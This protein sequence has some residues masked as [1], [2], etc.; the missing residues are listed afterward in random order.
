MLEG[1]QPKPYSNPSHD[2]LFASCSLLSVFCYPSTNRCFF[3]ALPLRF[4]TS[5]L[6]HIHLHPLHRLPLVQL[7]RLHNQLLQCRL[8]HIGR[9]PHLHMPHALPR[10]LQQSSRIRQHRAA[11]KNK[12]HMFLSRHETAHRPVRVKRRNLPRIHILLAS[13]QCL[14]HQRTQALHHALQFSRLRHIL[15]DPRPSFFSLNRRHRSPSFLN[16]PPF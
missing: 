7:G 12:R 5:P 15:V 3:T 8:L 9:R 13:P 10:P 4:L 14:L 16:P 1:P 11:Q 6:I 2:H